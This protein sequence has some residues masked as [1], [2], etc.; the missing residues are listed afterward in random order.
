MPFWGSLSFG[1]HVH[2]R[3]PV[4]HCCH[5]QLC[6][7]FHSHS[8]ASRGKP[9]QLWATRAFSCSE[10]GLPNVGSS[11][12]SS[13]PSPASV[14]SRPKDCT[15]LAPK[16]RLGRNPEGNRGKPLS[17]LLPGYGLILFARS[18]TDACFDKMTKC[19]CVRDV[20][21]AVRLVVVAVRLVAASVVECLL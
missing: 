6:Q 7:I 20:A 16:S 18:I 19:F 10:T 5:E 2:L 8:G 12:A 13:A 3:G 9:R 17:K 11:T 14:T 15:W 1:F 4:K 21:V